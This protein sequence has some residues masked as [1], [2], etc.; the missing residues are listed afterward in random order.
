MTTRWCKNRT[1][2]VWVACDQF[3]YSQF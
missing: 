1:E 2:T 3:G